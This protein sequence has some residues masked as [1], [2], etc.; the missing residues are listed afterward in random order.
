[1]KRLHTE[2]DF[3]KISKEY[4]RKRAMK[5][6]EEYKGRIKSI[7]IKEKSR[8]TVYKRNY[9]YVI[10]I[11]ASVGDKLYIIEE[12]DFSDNPA[13]YL[14]EGDECKVY[15]YNGEMYPGYFY[16]EEGKRASKEFLQQVHMTEKLTYSQGNQTKNMLVLVTLRTCKSYN[17]SY[18]LLKEKLTE[19]LDN[20]E[21]AV[22]D[23]M[24][25]IVEQAI[26]EKDEP[27][28][29][30]EIKIIVR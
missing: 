26:Q 2:L 5:Y 15:L 9:A 13:K 6:G 1:M 22:I 12:G 27:V 30:R 25:T 23:E 24:K 4:K 17:S 14:C 7:R 19:Y 18:F 16:A 10:L 8:N 20:S 29:I 28:Q 11:E 3:N 21:E